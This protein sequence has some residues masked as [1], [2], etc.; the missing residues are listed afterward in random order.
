MPVSSPGQWQDG[1]VS[2]CS[3]LPRG[4]FVSPFLLVNILVNIH[5]EW[6]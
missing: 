6:P 4:E 3:H 2:C 1:S 5:P